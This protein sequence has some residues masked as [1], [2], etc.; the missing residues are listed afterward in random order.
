MPSM[1]LTVIFEPLSVNSGEDKLYIEK[2]NK[3]LKHVKSHCIGQNIQ[4]AFSDTLNV[5]DITHEEYIKVVRT[6]IVGPSCS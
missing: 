5:L 1:P 2:W 6:T 4:T 3:I